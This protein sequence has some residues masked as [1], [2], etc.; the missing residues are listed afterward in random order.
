MEIV[1]TVYRIARDGPSWPTGIVAGD[2]AVDLD[3]GRQVIAAK[4]QLLFDENYPRH[5]FIAPFAVAAVVAPVQPALRPGDDPAST[6]DAPSFTKTL[7]P[8]E[9]LA[10]T[11]TSRRHER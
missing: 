10:F 1:N 9:W 4:Y 6:P 5:I 11:A 3:L 7:L 8:D 2:S